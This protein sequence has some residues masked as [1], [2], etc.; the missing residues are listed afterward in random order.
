VPVSALR[1]ANEY[2]GSHALDRPASK[3]RQGTKSRSKRLDDSDISAAFEQM[4]GEA[5]VQ[6]MER[7]ALLDPG[8]VRRFLEQ[9]AQLAGGHRL[10][11]LA[12][13]K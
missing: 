11:G 7:H 2:N 6:R 9:A 4:G 13:R 10:A 12:A 5:V 1:S 3:K 8:R